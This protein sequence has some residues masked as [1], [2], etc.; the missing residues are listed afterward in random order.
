MTTSSRV[1]TTDRQSCLSLDREEL[2]SLV[3]HTLAAEQAAGAVEV[4]LVD[5]KAI[6][7]LHERFLG[8]PGAT[9][10]ITFPHG[11]DPGDPT[12]EIPHLGEIVVS[13]ET[14]IRQAPDF[15]KEPELEAFQYVVHGV[16]H[17]L[18]YDDRVDEERER[19]NE[20]QSE[21]LESW[22]EGRG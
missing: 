15:L 20:R 13:T 3:L 2:E 4:V 8:V 22:R 5:D 16:L 21:I 18:G 10:V 9:D 19:M 12:E 6:A 14:A 11:D 1:I 7:E 17:L